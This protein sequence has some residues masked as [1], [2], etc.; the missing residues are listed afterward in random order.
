MSPR[1]AVPRDRLGA[2]LAHGHR[3]RRFRLR[4]LAAH[5][6]DAQALTVTRASVSAHDVIGREI[7]AL[8]FAD[9]RPGLLHAD[10]PHH[11]RPE[12]RP[13]RG[14]LEEMARIAALLLGALIVAGCAAGQSSP[15]NSSLV[16]S[17]TGGKGSSLSDAPPNDPAGAFEAELRAAGAEV[18]ETGAFNTDP[19]GGQGL[20]L[21]VA[22]QQ[23]RVYAYSTPEDREAVAARIDPT[24]P[25]NLGTTIVE[26]AGNPKFWQADRIL[27]LYLGS[28]LAVE[29]GITT[30][31]GQPFARGQGRNPG[32]DRHTC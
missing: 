28:D 6:D 29:S 3:R 16:P 26:W 21:C 7:K 1:Q 31:L 11:A 2:G 8:E 12:L 5:A 27:V 23:V 9:S 19:L 32:P 15:P 24:D 13:T 22:G 10:R 25:S 20:G 4:R 14:R 30:I 17:A 18:R